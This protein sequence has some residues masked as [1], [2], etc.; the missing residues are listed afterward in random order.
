MVTIKLHCS[1]KTKPLLEKCL[2]HHDGDKFWL[3]YFVNFQNAELSKK[4]KMFHENSD[5]IDR[6]LPK[7][8]FKNLSNKSNGEN[9]EVPATIL[10]HVSKFSFS[11]KYLCQYVK[12]F[13]DFEKTPPPPP[14]KL[15]KTEI[16]PEEL[17][18]KRVTHIL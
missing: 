1:K 14:P 2:P 6:Y 7:K 13:C 8:L 11:L 10:K 5:Y 12:V 15:G 4:H 18:E 9:I 17:R 16:K 3:N